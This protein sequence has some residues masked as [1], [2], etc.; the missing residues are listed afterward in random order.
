L[1]LWWVKVA[2]ASSG[3]T[4]HNTCRMRMNNIAKQLHWN[5]G[6]TAA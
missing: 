5:K 2:R 6:N 3:L 4:N 1:L